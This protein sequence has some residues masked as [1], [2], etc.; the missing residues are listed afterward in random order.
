ML[1]EGSGVGGWRLC[2]VVLFSAFT[3]YDFHCVRAHI[4]AD[5]FQARLSR[6]IKHWLI[7][8]LTHL[9]HLSCFKAQVLHL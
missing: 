9:E 1:C 2:T 8:N 6:V 7:L 3:K 4:N 5:G